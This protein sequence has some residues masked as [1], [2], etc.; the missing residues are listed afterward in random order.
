MALLQNLF[1]ND[2]SK[3]FLR[4]NL[5]AIGVET[6]KICGTVEDVG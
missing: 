6:V 1:W 5:Y 4:P 3:V 2:G